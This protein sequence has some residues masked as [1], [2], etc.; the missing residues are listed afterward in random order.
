MGRRPAFRFGVWRR[1]S[2]ESGGARREADSGRLPR[3]PGSSRRDRKRSVDLPCASVPPRDTCRPPS[4]AIT[5]FPEADALTAGPP[6]AHAHWSPTAAGSRSLTFPPLRAHSSRCTA[7]RGVPFGEPTA[8]HRTAA[9]ASGPA[10]YLPPG[11][12]PRAAKRATRPVV[13]RAPGRALQRFL[14]GAQLGCCSLD[15][16]L[17]TQQRRR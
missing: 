14:P 2:W 3:Q 17:I 6:L 9:R 12:P 10:A 11:S 1:I 13:R 16:W 4:A 7:P 15:S 8:A 5:P